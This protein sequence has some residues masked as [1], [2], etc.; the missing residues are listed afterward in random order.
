MEVGVPV[1]ARPAA[2]VDE[3]QVSD[4]GTR[5]RRETC[6]QGSLVRGVELVGENEAGL[7]RGDHRPPR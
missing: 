2:R 3:Q 5:Q 1:E 4:R 7:R 6:A